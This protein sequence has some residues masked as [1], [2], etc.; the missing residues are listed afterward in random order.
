[1]RSYLKE[2]ISYCIPASKAAAQGPCVSKSEPHAST[3]KKLLDAVLETEQSLMLMVIP[4][5]ESAI[6]IG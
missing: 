5:N 6:G 2:H 1:M 4:N 3:Q